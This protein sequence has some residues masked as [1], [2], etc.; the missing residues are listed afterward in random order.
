MLLCRCQFVGTSNENEVE[1]TWLL[2]SGE[3]FPGV[4]GHTGTTEH[5]LSGRSMGWCRE[6]P[7]GYGIPFDSTKHCH[8][9]QKGLWPGGSV[10]TSPPSLLPLSGGGGLQTCNC[11]WM[12]A[13]T[14]PMPLSGL[15]RPYLMCHYQVRDTSVPWGMACLGPAPPAADTQTIATKGDSGMPR[16]FQW[17]AWSLAVYLPGTATLE[18]CCPLQTC[19][20]TTGW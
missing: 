6:T 14:G 10:G 13:W 4:S 2:S 16:R 9:L 12:K 8:G 17:Q 7:A 5:P 3:K 15:T 19:L 20:W 18:C 11:W 1:I